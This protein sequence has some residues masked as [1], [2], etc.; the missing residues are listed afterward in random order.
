MRSSSFLVTDSGPR[1]LHK[2]DA[3]PVLGA[4]GASPALAAL[5]G[6][7]TSHSFGR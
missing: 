4:G 7:G 2:L 1:Y 5:V 6:V 3:L